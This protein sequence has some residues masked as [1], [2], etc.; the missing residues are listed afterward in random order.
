MCLLTADKHNH[1]GVVGRQDERCGKKR[2]PHFISQLKAYRLAVKNL[3]T[4]SLYMHN[5]W[6]PAIL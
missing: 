3:M 2:R 4:S 6:Q 1:A 5:L